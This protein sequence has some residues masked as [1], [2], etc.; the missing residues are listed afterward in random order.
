MKREWNI[1]YL[2]ILACFMVVFLHVSG[3]N[4]RMS[5]VNSV[6]WIIFNVYDSAVR[7][8]VPI[9]VMISGY[10]F[11][12][13]REM[14]SISTLLRK[15][16]LR[17]LYIYFIW[18]CFYGVFRI[19]RNGIQEQN[20][21]VGIIIE[22]LKSN[23]HLW[24]LPMLIS[25]Y[26]LLPILWSVSHYENGKY[27]KY[28]CLLFFVFG[29]IK[30]TVLSLFIDNKI[31][32]D[33]LNI[34]NYPLVEHSGYFLWGYYIGI[35]KNQFLKYNNIILI[36]L[37]ICT[38]GLSSYITHIDAMR[39]GKASTLLYSN[40]SITV[41]LEATLLF[42]IFM[43]KKITKISEHKKVIIKTISRLTFFTYLFHP[44]V[45]DCMKYY[46]NITSLSFNPLLSVPI[47][48]I[49]IFFVC[50]VFGSILDQVNLPLKLF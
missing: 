48:S 25:I 14:V 22:T 5:D 19:L 41:F 1:D 18:S 43:K 10:L 28:A 26:L 24:Y 47:L 33:L 40:F 50:L 21:F 20:I 9:F 42:I 23:F 29:I 11:L 13:K 44:F 37:L 4:F 2:R 6:E 17:F 35:K 12:S 27:L 30:S 49:V 36:I 34:F 16:I 38:I 39:L 31:I 15:Y 46:L 7:S 3:Q 8:S 32:S 45:I